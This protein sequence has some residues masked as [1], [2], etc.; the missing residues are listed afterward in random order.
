[1][2]IESSS[3]ATLKEKQEILVKKLEETA[4][5]IAESIIL[6]LDLTSEIAKNIDPDEPLKTAYRIRESGAFT[7]SLIE[8]NLKIHDEIDDLKYLIKT[9]ELL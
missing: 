2:T 7:Q 4:S 6:S 1:M 8:E 3:L 9:G 5:M